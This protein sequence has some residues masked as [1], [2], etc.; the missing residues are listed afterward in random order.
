MGSIKCQ[1]WSSAAPG[2]PDNEK[3]LGVFCSLLDQFE[4]VL[5]KNGTVAVA[6]GYH[7]IARKLLDRLENV[8]RGW[9]DVL[10]W[11]GGWRSLTLLPASI[12]APQQL[13]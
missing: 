13:V 3:L 11:V 10:E 1:T 2:P 6:T 9:G 7:S 4:T 12:S 8:A 5:D